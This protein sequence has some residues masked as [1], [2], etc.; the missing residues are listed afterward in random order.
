MRMVIQ[1]TTSLFLKCFIHIYL[2]YL[3]LFLAEERRREGHFNCFL[4]IYTF[5][6]SFIFNTSYL[7]FTQK[8]TLH[9]ILGHCKSSD[10]HF[11]FYR[12]V[13]LTLALPGTNKP[14]A[15]VA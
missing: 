5:S 14:Q 11:N 15:A 6:L 9:N 2:F 1:Y 8:K 7:C 10:D 12:P 13:L 3:I 4:S